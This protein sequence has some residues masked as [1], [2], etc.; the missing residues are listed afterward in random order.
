M[1]NVLLATVDFPEGL[2]ISGRCQLVEARVCRLKRGK[3]SGENNAQELSEALPFLE[4]E[5]HKQLLYKMRVDACLM[6]N[7]TVPVNACALCYACFVSGTAV[8]SF[9]GVSLHP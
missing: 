2:Q 7:T 1:P 8:V 9:N 6:G 3:L 4:L 5:L